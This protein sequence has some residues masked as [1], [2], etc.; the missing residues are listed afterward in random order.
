MNKKTAL[1]L[2][3]SL[4][5]FALVFVLALMVGKYSIPID[6]FFKA[7]F[8]SDEAF[9]T[10]RSVIFNLR[11]PRTI[12]AG[13]TGIGLSLS[14]LLYQEIFQNKLTSPD[15]LGVSSGA[16]VGA[17]L[18]IILG[19]GSVFVSTFAFI[20]GVMTVGLTL[21][22]SRL[23]KNGSSITL[24]L[25]GII[26][27]GFMSA[28]LSVIKFLAD[29]VTTLSSITYWLMGSF[30]NSTMEKVW[31]LLPVV[32]VCA[33]ILVLLSWRINIVAMGREQAQTKGIKYG[34][35]RFLIIGIATLLTATSV[36]FSGTIGWIGLVIPHVVRTIV[37]R[38][39]RR[40]IPLC[41]TFGGVFMIVVDILSRSFTNNEIPLSAVTGVIGTIIFVI[42]LLTKRRDANVDRN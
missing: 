28:L 38:D 22:L 14:G 17:A 42:I 21:L 9:A 16:A 24:V 31:I 10:Q 35:Y 37:G 1:F 11:L 26:V 40:T 25:A 8:T 32:G 39:T 7:A 19:L 34:L 41:I 36:A 27:G 15:L 5:C 29:P 20:T 4:L 18:A 2:T 3:I 33:V 6:E 30:E 12:V 13:L 23:F